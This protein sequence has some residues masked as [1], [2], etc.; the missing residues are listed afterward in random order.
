MVYSGWLSIA[1]VE[2]A[3]A[4]RV[5]A[6]VRNLIPG[7]PL[8]GCQGCD[9]LIAA[10]GDEPYYSPLQDDAPWLDVA[11]PATRDF[12]GFY[13]LALEGVDDSTSSTEVVQSIGPGGY[14]NVPRDSTREIR[15]K[16]V[17][18]AGNALALESG[19]A[20]LKEALLPGLCGDHGG[21]C[22]GA[23][24]CYYAACP[25]LTVCYSDDTTSKSASFPNVTQ[26]TG[27][28]S[29]A[30]TFGGDARLSGVI[31]V[32]PPSDG[33]TFNWGVSGLVGDVGNTTAQPVSAFGPATPQRT[34]VVQN[35]HFTLNTATW[36]TT[37][38]VLTRVAGI[39]TDGGAAGHVVP[40]G[41]GG[42]RANV[43]AAQFGMNV[44]SFELQTA[45]G[46]SEFTVNIRSA[47][48]S[49]VV[50][51]ETFS[52]TDTWNPYTLFVPYARGNILEIVSTV[53][54][55]ISRVL[56][57]G[58][59]AQMPYFD[60]ATLSEMQPSKAEGVPT[61]EYAVSWLGAPHASASRMRWLGAASFSFCGADLYAWVEVVSGYGSFDSHWE[62]SER[63]S[64]EEQAARYER[65]MYDV[66]VLDGPKTIQELSTS[67]G[68]GRVVEF[69][70]SA[71]NPFAY[72]TARDLLMRY[73]LPSLPQQTWLDT[74]APVAPPTIIV[75]PDCPP[76]P[77][78]PRPPL[79]PNSCIA[80]PTLWD[81]YSYP[82]P[83]EEVAAWA[84]TLITLTL[85]SATT[86]VRQVRARLT[87]NPFE[88]PVATSSRKNRVSNPQVATALTDWV[89]AIGGTSGVS[90]FARATASP[91]AGFVAH[92]R[93]QVTTAPTAGSMYLDAQ[94]TGTAT[95]AV[96]AGKTYTFSAY[97]RGIALTGAADLL[98]IQWLDG[99]GA[100]LSTT[101]GASTPVSTNVW[102]RRS[103]TGVAPA[104][105]VR[106][107]LIA[108]RTAT[109]LPI[110]NYMDATGFLFEEGSTVQSYFD[111]STPDAAGWFYGWQGT[112][113]ASS[114]LGQASVIDPYSYC[115]EFI[116]S[117]LPA[118]AELVVDGV[119]TRAWASIGGAPSVPASNLLYGTDGSP[120]VWPEMACGIPYVLTVDV[121]VGTGA[122]LLVSLAL[123]RRE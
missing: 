10:L 86:D 74:V 59:T 44:L 112:A 97:Q 19:M 95:N 79:V 100:I 64:D 73:P 119:L 61:P 23:T 89:G 27:P 77:A 88:Y 34:N 96:T 45:G 18:V 50:Q 120:I 30:D 38:S 16:G 21:A 53:P 110:G 94:N 69:V 29:V 117:Y 84:K 54:F 93:T 75:D 37:S 65:S 81:R 83:A 87:P 92:T 51:T 6:Y 62:Q 104:S 115:G 60:G 48:T 118:N 121:P 31:V 35:P 108:R 63:I 122:G 101:T 72:S 57:E 14:N 76:V 80:S 5:E 68:I 15:V 85:T 111:G 49:A 47:T 52:S 46:A 25:E 40:T 26:S 102:N 41:T 113:N 99:A 106:A 33:L 22:V 91:P 24:M 123:T 55:D 114:S 70:L 56:L 105:A 3:N 90:S 32:S 11:N 28:F 1:G 39:A 98:Y 107:R 116:L 20:W 66:V 13:P 12:Y 78:A 71:A 7:F 36:T 82:I 2:I 43:Q 4:A 103:V 8:R 9:S 109:A 17:L 58:G 42:I 67:V